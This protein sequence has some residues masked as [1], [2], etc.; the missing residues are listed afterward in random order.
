[1][2]GHY[3]TIW[4]LG[5]L[6]EVF[7]S[8]CPT[9]YFWNINFFITLYIQFVHRGKASFWWWEHLWSGNLSHVIGRNAESNVKE[10]FTILYGSREYITEE[11]TDYNQRRQVPG[12]VSCGWGDIDWADYVA[13]SLKCPTKSDEVDPGAVGCDPRIP[14]H[15]CWKSYGIFPATLRSDN[16]NT[17]IRDENWKWIEVL[18]FQI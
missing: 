7:F 2:D 9:F 1:M 3:L 16:P 18:L 14:A 15:H 8:K 17:K 6:I 10:H 11:L 4:L 12:P 5:Y 13:G